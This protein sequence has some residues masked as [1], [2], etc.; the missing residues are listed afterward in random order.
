MSVAE[1]DAVYE[2]DLL[3]VV[4]VVVVDRHPMHQKNRRSFTGV[5]ADRC[6]PAILCAVDA[7][8]GRMEARRKV[9]KA[10]LY[11]VDMDPLAVVLARRVLWLVVGDPTLPIDFMEKNKQHVATFSVEMEW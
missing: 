7:L 11:G 4:P 9:A 5:V 10:C 6:L 2:G 1:G 3:A 8:L